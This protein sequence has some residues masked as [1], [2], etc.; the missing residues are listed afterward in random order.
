MRIC[1]Y[2][3]CTVPDKETVTVVSFGGRKYHVDCFIQFIQEEK[4]EKTPIVPR[5]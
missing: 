3:K 1:D 5:S 4:C 2:P